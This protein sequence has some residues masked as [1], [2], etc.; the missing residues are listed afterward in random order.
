VF[1]AQ[2][3]SPTTLAASAPPELSLIA[4]LSA[5]ASPSG[6]SGSSSSSGG[7]GAAA[8][9]AAGVA[10]RCAACL[11]LQNII[12]RN[13]ADAV[14]A[15]LRYKKA[16][17]AGVVPPPCVLFRHHLLMQFDHLPRQAWD[18]HSTNKA[19]ATAF[20]LRAVPST[21]PSGWRS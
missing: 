18:T 21:L 17:P 2:E 7:S 5:L 3:L 10:L 12:V 4:P 14:P 15:V 11:A 8:A 13:G 6:G 1:C 9:A 16:K 20:C 19:N